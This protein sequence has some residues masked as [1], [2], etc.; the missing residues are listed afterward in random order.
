MVSR[1]LGEGIHHA[2]EGGKIA[3]EFLQEALAQGNYDT[4]VMR[5]YHDRWMERFGYDFRW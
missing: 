3:G 4:Q 2:M 1:V 5:I